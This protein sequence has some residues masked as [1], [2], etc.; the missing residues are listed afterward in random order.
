MSMF[1]HFSAHPT[2]TSAGSKAV[3]VLVVVFGTIK[4]LFRGNF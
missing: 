3:Q 2:L 1:E 4:H